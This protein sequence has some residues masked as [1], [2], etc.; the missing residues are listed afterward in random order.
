MKT[1]L[2]ADDSAIVRN[3]IKT[4]LYEH[5][6]LVEVENGEEVVKKAQELDI[7][8]FLLDLNM[9]VMDGIE[10]TRN[11]RCIPKYANTPILMLTSEIKEDKKKEGK[12]AGATGWISK[13]VDQEDFL[14]AI[15][16]LM[17]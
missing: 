14:S 8:L 4:T 16:K 3:L 2:L 10:A 5:Y 12:E 7:D 17:Q 9:P 15:N 6:N 1:I 13:S 11:L